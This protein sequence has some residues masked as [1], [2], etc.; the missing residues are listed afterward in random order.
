MP[1]RAVLYQA[2]LLN[3]G[4]KNNHNLY[5][6]FGGSYSQYDPFI[7]PNIETQNCNYANN[8][9][10]WPSVVEKEADSLLNIRSHPGY[11]QKK[12]FRRRRLGG[13][14]N[15]EEVMRHQRLTHIAVERNRRKQVNEYLS[16]LR[17]LMP[18]S[19]AKKGDQAS[20][21]G[22][23]INFVKELEQ[24]LQCLESLK[25]TTNSIAGNSSPSS[26]ILSQISSHLYTAIL[27]LCVGEKD[28]EHEPKYC[29]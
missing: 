22:G 9:S 4:A 19:Y 18:H 26:H 12:G 16:V 28:D 3:H 24:K 5:S 21:V 6:F 7:L 20:I 11:I 29:S 14:M 1:L 10:Y 8:R 23:A 15:E 13:G 27:V 25:H 2:D 17:S